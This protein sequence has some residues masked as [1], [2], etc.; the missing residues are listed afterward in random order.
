VAA[1][2]AAAILRYGMTA[3]VP[4][5]MEIDISGLRPLAGGLYPAEICG[6]LASLQACFWHPESTG[7]A[8]VTTAVFAQLGATRPVPAVFLD[9]G[10]LLGNMGVG[11]RSELT[12]LGG[13]LWMSGEQTALLTRTAG[14]RDRGNASSRS[15]GCETFAIGS[16]RFAFCHRLNY[17]NIPDGRRCVYRRHRSSPNCQNRLPAVKPEQSLEDKYNFLK[18][19]TATSRTGKLGRAKHDSQAALYSQLQR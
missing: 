18:V 17:P 2:V 5:T 14:R 4:T 3:R 13:A 1:A 12:P 15:A 7:L 16:N 9:T 19:P 6:G 10:H 8:L 11:L